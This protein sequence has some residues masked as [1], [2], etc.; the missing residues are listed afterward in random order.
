M[1][2]CADYLR[3]ELQDHVA[4]VRLHESSV[5][6]YVVQLFAQNRMNPVRSLQRIVRRRVDFFG[7]LLLDE[8]ELHELTHRKHFR[9]FRSADL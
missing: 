7:S 5:V 2:C 3:G 9:R 4:S 1:R 6:Q 8:P